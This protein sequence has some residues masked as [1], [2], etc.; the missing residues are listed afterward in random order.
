MRDIFGAYDIR[1]RYPGEIDEVITAEIVAGLA[2]KI[3]KKG[4][5]VVGF[6]ARKSSPALYEA[7]LGVLGGRALP[8][9]MITTPMLY[10]LVNKLKTS[11]G[12]M[13]TASHN[14]KD[15]NGL[16]VVGKRGAP[17]SGD[18]IQRL[19]NIRK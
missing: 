11:G 6:D 10:F 9:G 15:W 18:E 17:I 19:L 13:V 12:I 7:A 16:K 5:I 2:E 14:P 4:K 3:F 8:A 1:G